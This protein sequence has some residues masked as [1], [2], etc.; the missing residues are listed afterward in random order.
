MTALVPRS[1]LRRAGLLP[2]RRKR[3][4]LRRYAWA[5]ILLGVIVSYIWIIRA[6]A[7]DPDGPG[8]FLYAFHDLVWLPVFGTVWLK[9]E[10]FSLIWVFPVA[11]GGLMILLEWLGLFDPIRSLQ[12]R[13]LRW[14]L[15]RRTGRAIILVF[16]FIPLTGRAK[17][18]RTVLDGEIETLA[19]RL[20]SGTATKRIYRNLS[21][22]APFRTRL[23]RGR[24][25]L[26]RDVEAAVL[27]RKT[28]DDPRVATKLTAASAKSLIAQLT[29][30]FS[31]GP[32][33]HLASILSEV[34]LTDGWHTAEINTVEPLLRHAA[35]LRQN[36]APKA[37]ETALAVMIAARAGGRPHA[38]AL[39]TALAQRDIR[40]TEA[41]R[42]A[43]QAEPQSPGTIDLE[44]WLAGIEGLAAP[45]QPAD[46]APDL[47][48]P[49]PDR[50]LGEQF[51][52]TGGRR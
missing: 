3:N 22:L 42:T 14:L 7:V 46:P 2:A 33:A 5:T 27:I 36:P 12:I 45:D 10:P 30:R 51:A 40:L 37:A 48:R 25:D 49:R 15:Y 52:L 21:R 9:Y 24:G 18:A 28:H 20:K 31:D 11:M 47:E 32:A 13:M 44:Y 17:L 26:L 1:G 35:R 19:G 16:S 50:D 6:R 38:R 39:A 41:G 29:K 23:E 43:A 4:Y 8:R 34:W